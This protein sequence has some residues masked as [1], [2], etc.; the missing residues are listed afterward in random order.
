MNRPARTPA[1]VRAAALLIALLAAPSAHSHGGEPHSHEPEPAVAAPPSVAAGSRAEAATPDVEAVAVLDGDQ[2][3]LYLDRFATN[4]P[5]TDATVELEVDGQPVPVQASA[6][7]SYRATLGDP[8]PGTRSLVISIQA[9][10]LVDLLALEL[11]VPESAAAPPEPS[12]G[13]GRLV[14]IGAVAALLILL[15]LLVVRARRAGHRSP[16]HA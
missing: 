11:P 14:L 16:H 8:R 2:L 1:T 10:E 9:G 13:R 5:I 4:E 12:D 15:A 3:T 7:G 6:D